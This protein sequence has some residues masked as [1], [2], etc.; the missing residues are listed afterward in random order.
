[1][2]NIIMALIIISL[3]TTGC[4]GGEKPEDTVKNYLSNIDNDE[5]QSAIKCLAPQKAEDIDSIKGKWDERKS[6][7]Y[8]V[9][10]SLGLNTRLSVATLQT[11]SLS[12]DRARVMATLGDFIVITYDLN[13]VNKKWLIENE[14]ASYTPKAFTLLMDDFLFDKRYYNALNETYTNI[15]NGDITKCAITPINADS[16]RIYMSVFNKVI[17]HSD[18]SQAN[19][20]TALEKTTIN[21]DAQYIMSSCANSVKFNFYNDVSNKTK[22]YIE[23][24]LKEYNKFLGRKNSPKNYKEIDDEFLIHLVNI[25]KSFNIGALQ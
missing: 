10:D 20:N 13:M 24:K 25:D 6:D 16:H 2:K 8:Y 14:T 18:T 22:E 3:L 5:Y 11:Q 21:N 9:L 1:M 23:L 4:G 7:L 19:K 12:K 17:S 15:Q